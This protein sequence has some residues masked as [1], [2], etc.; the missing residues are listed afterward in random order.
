MEWGLILENALKAGVGDFAAVFALAAIGLNVHFGFVVGVFI[1]LSTLVVAP[2]LKNVGAL[3]IL[4]LILLVRPQ[5]LL[6]LPLLH[7]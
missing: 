7:I 4:I 6:G 2:E 3:A 5:G 1:Q